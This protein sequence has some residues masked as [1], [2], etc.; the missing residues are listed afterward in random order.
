[1]FR[2]GRWGARI[3][4][5]GLIFGGVTVVANPLSGAD[6]V[7]VVCDVFDGDGVRVTYDAATDTATW[8]LK[9]TGD[10]DGGF[11]ENYDVTLAGSGTSTGLGL[12]SGSGVVR[13]VSFAVAVQFSNSSRSF[14]QNQAWTIPVSGYPVT[15][16]FTLSGPTGSGAGTIWNR[17]FGKCPGSGGSNA[18]RF[19]WEQ[20][21]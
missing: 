1:M 19:Q 20:Q 5:A 2:I 15:T 4:A 17:I 21:V 18:A 12:C 7:P 11:P 6:P 3:V 13:N 14:T 8:T 16:P 9:G 10:C